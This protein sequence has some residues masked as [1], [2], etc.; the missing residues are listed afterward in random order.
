[1]KNILYIIGLIF[2]LTGCES[3]ED[4]YSEY[5]TPK[6]RYVGMVSDLTIEQG[7]KRFRLNWTNSV[8]AAIVNIKVKWED[9][10]GVADSILLPADTETYITDTIFSNQNYKFL[11]SS[12]DSRNKES[13]TEEVYEDAFT[14]ES[15]LVEMYEVV[16]KKFFLIE[17]QL[18][19]MLY[20]TGKDI[21]DVDLNYTSEGNAKT[22]SL[23]TDDYEN[24]IVLVEDVDTDEPIT[25][26]GK[27]LIPNCFDSITVSPY[28]LDPAIKNWSGSFLG[29][30]RLQ[31]DM[32][33]I[34]EDQLDT[35][36][37]LYVDYSTTTLEDILYMPNLKKVVLGKKRMNN[38]VNYI[39]DE[40]Y[41]STL[42]DVDASVFALNKMHEL[43]GMEVE[44]YGNQFLLAD[45]LDFEIRH[46]KNAP[47]S[48]AVPDDAD[49]WELSIIDEPEYYENAD[50]IN[51]HPY[52]L[53]YL[54][55]KRY[56]DWQSIALKDEVKTHEILYDMKE[57]KSV[58]GFQFYQSTSSYTLKYLP[59]RVEVYIST[60]GDTW[61][62]AFFQATLD[63][64]G[65]PGEVTIVYMNEPKNAQYIKLVVKDVERSNNN[66]V[67]IDEFVP[68]L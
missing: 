41:V 32:L 53:E 37:T 49:Q 64:G 15:T 46:T 20:D 67:V 48:V 34:D 11:V 30:L 28:V 42:E 8:D 55:G 25:I 29:T 13:F 65:V 5:N 3:M 56:Y 62:S 27:M 68:I 47:P 7:W 36:T 66:Y 16:Q 19:L 4:T 12:I 6:E 39:T 2:V 60:D 1:M 22:I 44:I 52:L 23:E 10:N 57:V 40:N 63:V 45:T 54:I 26:Q 51:N 33:D 21:Y 18:I 31:F 17:D 58:K 35:I 14:E 50:T 43:T 24:G 38:K 59:Q 9:K 61:E